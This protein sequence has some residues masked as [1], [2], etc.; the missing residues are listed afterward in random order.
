MQQP[1]TIEEKDQCNTR[2]TSM[3]FIYKF[4]RKLSINYVLNK[5]RI[6]IYAIYVLI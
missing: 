4:W 2:M 1:N 6:S 5:K 3:Y